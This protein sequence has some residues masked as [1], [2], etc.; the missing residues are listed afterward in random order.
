MPQRI[1]FCTS[2]LA[3]ILS[4]LSGG[5]THFESIQRNVLIHA[6]NARVNFIPIKLE[7]I[8]RGNILQGNQ[9]VW[10]AAYHVYIDVG[11]T[12]G[13]TGSVFIPSAMTLDMED[14]ELHSPAN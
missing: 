6:L 11:S 10:P 7:E 12:G 5:D 2:I 9:F 4:N 3:D 1:Q 13:F 14:L 8:Y